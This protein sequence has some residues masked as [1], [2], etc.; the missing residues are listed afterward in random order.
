[1]SDGTTVS[2]GSNATE[3]EA[4]AAITSQ[5]ALDAI[6]G[7]RV[8][9]EKA[10]YADYKDLK[11]KADAFDQSESE[12]RTDIEKANARAEAAEQRAAE[13]E[14]AKQISDLAAGKAI[15]VECLTG[16]AEER[17]DAIASLI[18]QAGK[19]K[20]PA[21]NPSQGRNATHALNGDGLEDMLRSKLNI[22]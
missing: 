1:M 7:D 16:T 6:I 5:E 22:T 18:T 19:P 14:A 3:G 9:R 4:F 13:V 10:K 12:K 11:T 8:K 15:P 2:E 17:A 20:T 21:P